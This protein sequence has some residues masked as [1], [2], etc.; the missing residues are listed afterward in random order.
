[1]NVARKMKENIVNKV[2]GRINVK[3]VE[4]HSFPEPSNLLAASAELPEL[5]PNKRKAEYL[6]AVGEAFCNVDEQWL[7]TAQY[8][9]VHDWL[10]DIKV[11]EIGQPTL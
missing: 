9:E 3:G 11:L 8:N 1:M 4:Y 10:M 6:S 5:V 7:R 2:G